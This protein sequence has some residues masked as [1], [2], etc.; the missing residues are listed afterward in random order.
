MRWFGSPASCAPASELQGQHVSFYKEPAA[1]GSGSHRVRRS[2]GKHRHLNDELSSDREHVM[3][4]HLS[5]S[6][7]PS[8]DKTTGL[9]E[10]VAVISSGFLLCQL[11]PCES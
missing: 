2:V 10:S 11:P 7:I 3:F 1:I 9:P 5:R 4:S 8:G 6:L